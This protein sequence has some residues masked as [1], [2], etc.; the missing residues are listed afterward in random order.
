MTFTSALIL[1]YYI[2][3]TQLIMKTDTSDY[4]LIAILFI[5]NEEN[6]VHLVALYSHT[7]I[8]VEV[9]YDTH[10]KELLVNFKA[11]KI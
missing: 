1:T 8:M 9:N 5:I 10:N 11:F 2:P 7:F 4:T 3:N 6:E